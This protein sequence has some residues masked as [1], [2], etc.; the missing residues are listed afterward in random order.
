MASQKFHFHDGKG[1]A[2]LGVRVTPRATKNEIV[3]ALSDGTIRVRLISGS[4]DEETNKILISFL[5]EVLETQ[6]NK[7]EIVAGAAGRDKL[8]AIL[9][10]DTETVH[11]RIIKHLQ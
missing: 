9:D 4:S 8:I 5:S 2:S 10:L 3:E 11:Q 6:P 7:L 1:G